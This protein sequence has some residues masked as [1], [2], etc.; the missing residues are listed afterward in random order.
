MSDLKEKILLNVAFPLADKLMGTCA[1]EWYHRIS[2]MNTWTKEQIEKWQNEQLK[3]FITHAYNHTV[4]YHNLF[5]A[6]GVKPEDFSSP[7]DLQKI[8]IINKDIIRNHFDELVPD[9]IN[10][11]KYRKS[12]TGGTTGEPMYYFCDEQTWGYVTAAKI[13][14]WKITGYHYGDAFVALGSASLFPEKK[15]WRREIYDRMRNE[16]GLNGMNLSDDICEQYVKYIKKNHIRYIYGYAA[17]IYLLTKYIAHRGYDLSF[18]EAVFSTSEKL[19]KEYR[20]LIE[21]TFKCKVMD[22]YGAKDA[23]ITAYEI[24]PGRYDVGYNAI[25]EIINPD[26]NGVGSLIST[27]FLNYSFPMIRYEFGDEGILANDTSYN[28]QSI[29]E[30]I[31]RSSD[32]MRLKNGNNVTGPGFT[33]LMQP[34]DIVAYEIKQLSSECIE[35]IIQKDVARY[36]NEQ[37]KKIIEKVSRFIGEGCKLILTYVDEFVPLKNGKRKY[38]IVKSD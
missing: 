10:E 34:F 7:A 12:R 37:E 33:I 28:G 8:P 29:R 20:Q 24:I 38:F 17:S 14:A 36:T 35:L 32:V 18:V 16:R 11:Y 30:V 2:L 23:G 19:T 4:Y 25:C 26:K 3:S 1:M 13:Y 31:G 22:C 27:N 9:N 21:N 15:N 6:L 5:D